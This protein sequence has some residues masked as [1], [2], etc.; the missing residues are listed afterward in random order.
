MNQDKKY[1]KLVSG[2]LVAS[3]FVLLAGCNASSADEQSTSEN[4]S[5][6][7]I[8]VAF[9]PNESATEF[10]AS[11]AEIQEVIADAT[12][13]EVEI[14]TSTD[15][16]I[17]IES[18]A[19]GQVDL[20][21]MGAEGYI[22]ANKKN[23]NVQAILT[24][25]GPSGT[26]ED[27]L[28]YSFIAVNEEDSAQY[29]EGDGYKLDPIKGQK[30]SFVSNSSTSGFKVPSAAIVEQFDLENSDE[31][32]IDGDFFD[33]VLFGGSHQGSAV[34]LLKGDADVAAFMNMPAYFEVVEGEEN[35]AGMLYE[36]KADAEA[37]FDTVV[38]E[39]AR[40]IKSTPVLNGPFVANE[41]NLSEETLSKIVA[42]MTSDEVSD[43]E[44]IFA[45]KDTDKVGLYEKAGDEH[46]IEVEDD[47][48][49]PIRD[50]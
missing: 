34:N 20:A 35:K 11:R 23:E 14:V 27:A 25:T 9:Y 44:K 29:Q 21:Y 36:V 40:V 16:N 7:P 38:G 28:Y 6:E 2:F 18:I 13:R 12:G 15:Y 5:T 39:Q 1:L 4:E 45:P 37:P 19:N 8:K 31:L 32:I 48:Y 10:E 49:D 50:L 22:E 42:A 41:D 33:K 17:V 3:S 26:L 47:F 46:Y 43:N 24:N 30:F